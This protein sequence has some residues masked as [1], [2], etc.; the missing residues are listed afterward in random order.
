MERKVIYIR[1]I[2]LTAHIEQEFYFKALVE[3][4]IQVEY[5]DISALYPFIPQNLERYN[6][7]LK[8]KQVYFKS[9]SDLEKQ[10]KHNKHALF[11]S[12]MTLEIRL[13]K[14]WLLFN[15]YH[16]RKVVLA[17]LPIAFSP[18]NGS[19]KRR[20]NL[21]TLI[22]KF[23]DLI[24]KNLFKYKIIK[25]Y[26]YVFLGGSEG[27]RT[28]GLCGDIIINQCKVYNIHSIDYDKYFQITSKYDIEKK[29]YIVFLDQYIPFHPD[30]AICG[31][32]PP[33]SIEYYAALNNIFNAIE[34]KYNMPIVIAAHPKAIRYKDKNYY[35]GRKVIFNKTEELILSSNLVILHNSTSVST[36]IMANKPILYLSMNC[37]EKVNKPFNDTI[38]YLSNLFCSSCLC[39][40]EAS[41]DDL[42]N[43]TENSTNEFDFNSYKY[44]YLT[45][46]NNDSLRNEDIIV[47]AINDIFNRNV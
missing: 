38:K 31:L 22:I 39:V 14:L 44:K 3:N 16:C 4:G 6:S 19:V 1:Y 18:L 8:I 35:E 25:G 5:W 29:N 33:D 28:I 23:K 37:I 2:P 43:I 24:I 17:H 45:S 12:I 32:T 9:F 26:E 21:K 30:N 27:W 34:T 15:K 42:T 10:I 20:C 47:E 11:W 7:N 13:W 46:L 36:A 40:E 41:T